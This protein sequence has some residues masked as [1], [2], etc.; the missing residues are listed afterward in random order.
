MVGFSMAVLEQEV[1]D[2][3]AGASF[4]PSLRSP[5]HVVGGED[6]FSEIMEVWNAS[7]P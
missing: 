4:R 3:D 5:L 6:I 2:E 7:F 1:L